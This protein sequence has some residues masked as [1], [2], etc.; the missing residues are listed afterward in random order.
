MEINIIVAIIAFLILSMG[1]VKAN[2]KQSHL[3][4]PLIAIIAGIIIGP[5]VLELISPFS[6]EKPNEILHQFARFTLALAVMASA[7]RLPIDFLKKNTKSFLIILCGGMILMLLLASLLYFIFGLG[8]WESLLIGAILAPTDPVL[9]TSIIA[10]N[11]AEENIPVRV[12]N[13]ITAESASNDGLAY[14]FVLLPVVA[15]GKHDLPLGEWAKEILLWQNIGAIILG[16]GLGYGTGKAFRYFHKKESMV[17]KS[18]MAIALA[19]TFLIA[20]FFP[21]IKMNG[22]IGVFAAGIAFQAIVGT[23]IE[24]RHEE[25]QSMME[26]IFIVPVFVIFG[27]MLPWTDWKE[28]PLY[29]WIITPLVIFFRRIPTL[30]ILKPLLPIFPSKDIFFMGWFGPVGVAAL[31]YITMLLTQYPGHE[32]LW[33]VV[34]YAVLFSTFIHAVTANPLSK[35]LYSSKDD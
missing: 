13:M 19:F 30:F 32:Q 4:E 14:V 26:R 21:I 8:L 6:W 7:L 22:I 29:A 20:T 35:R 31:F 1:L 12:R 16:V 10:S 9:A 2:I 11:F 15:M 18:L 25:V 23:E 24:T 5:K 3:S 17:T 27:A 33:P 28:M 34:A